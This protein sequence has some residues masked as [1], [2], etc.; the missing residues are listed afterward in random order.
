MFWGKK[1]KQQVELHKTMGRII[2]Q[3]YS[4]QADFPEL[5]DEAQQRSENRA[6]RQVPLAIFVCDD[7]RKPD[8]VPGFSSD[9]SMYGLAAL[10]TKKIR[11][12]EVFIVVGGTEERVILQGECVRCTHCGL[13]CYKS[14]FKLNM[15]L[16]NVEFDSFIEFVDELEKQTREAGTST[17]IPNGV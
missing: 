1:K 6:K 7:G 13:G 2:N 9:I 16:P 4:L 11:L 10:T 5:S 12:G 3:S 14:G 17:A 15:V 8:Y